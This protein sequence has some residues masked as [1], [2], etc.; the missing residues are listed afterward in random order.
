MDFVRKVGEKG[1][2]TMAWPK[3]YGGGGR[4]YIDYAIYTEEMFYNRAPLYPVWLSLNTAGPTMYTYGSDAHKKELLPGISQ[5]EIVFCQGFSEPEAGSDLASL[6]TTA[7]VDGDFFVI[8]GQK[9]WTSYAHRAQYMLLMARTDPQAPKH[10]GISQFVVDMKTPGIEVHPLVDMMEHHDFNEVFLNDLR[11]PKSCLMGEE[12][13]G[14]HQAMTTV[15]FERSPINGVAESR[16]IL[17]DIM[18]HVKT[19]YSDGLIIANNPL[20]QHKLAE[21]VTEVE[22][23]RLLCYNVAWLQSQGMIPE[24]EASIAKVFSTELKYK[25]TQVVMEIIGVTS[26]IQ[27]GS[28]WCCLNGRMEREHLR[29]LGLLFGG[30]TSEVQRNV[31]ALRG[32]G[33]P[34]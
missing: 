34:R 28:N 3:E 24:A 25:L 9:V 13:N 27:P 19:T 20:V 29:S 30:G 11:I 22:I 2:L 21:L 8:N 17:D 5:G 31:I 16:R 33:L 18:N 7:V 6:Q 26:L 32:L 10:R 1:W 15:S 14:W 4:S 23:A 12:N